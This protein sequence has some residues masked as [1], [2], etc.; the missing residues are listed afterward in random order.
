MPNSGLVILAPALRAALVTAAL[1]ASPVS[2][3]PDTDLRTAR[4]TTRRTS[5]SARAGTPAER[6]RTSL[7]TAPGS[8]VRMTADSTAFASGSVLRTTARGSGRTV[9]HSSAVAAPLRRVPRRRFPHHECRLSV[10]FS[11]P[12]AARFSHPTHRRCRRAGCAP[13]PPEP[14]ICRQTPPGGVPFMLDRVDALEMRGQGADIIGIIADRFSGEPVSMLWSIADF[15]P[16][17]SRASSPRGRGS[18]G[19]RPCVRGSGGPGGT[20]SPSPG[21]STCPEG[22]RSGWR[23]PPR[24]VPRRPARGR[25]QHRTATFGVCGTPVVPPFGGRVYSTWSPPSSS[26]CNAR[27][28]T[29]SSSSSFSRPAASILPRM[30]LASTWA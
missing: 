20:S 26:S 22:L 23:N 27:A 5:V 7:R 24:A 19:N 3:S 25:F 4:F 18:P 28:A 1:R 2:A 9:R 17:Y 10:L 12:E 6:D 11:T 14:A 21:P 13:A 30:A 29:T 8:R 15:G 16:R